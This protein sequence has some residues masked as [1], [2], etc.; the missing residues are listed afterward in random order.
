MHDTTLTGAGKS[1]LLNAIAGRKAL[2]G[3]E[4][5]LDNHPLTKQ[6]RRKISYV[7]QHDIFLQ[8]LTFWD[9][10]WVSYEY[11]YNNDMDYI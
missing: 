7:L 4:V 2:T 3:G 5:R 11:E 10:L 9:T 8:D 6:M 1:T